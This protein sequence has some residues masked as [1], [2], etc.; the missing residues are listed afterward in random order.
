MVI[1]GAWLGRRFPPAV[2]E[3]ALKRG[4][5]ALLLV[6]GIWIC[7]SALNQGFGVLPV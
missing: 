6:M 7:A 2:S 5:F 4:V 1:L 3:Q